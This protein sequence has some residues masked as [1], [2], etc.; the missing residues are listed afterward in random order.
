MSKANKYAISISFYLP[1]FIAE[2]KKEEQVSIF[3][4]N[5]NKPKW[6]FVKLIPLLI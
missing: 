4:L 5:F 2:E 3:Q 6:D 1:V